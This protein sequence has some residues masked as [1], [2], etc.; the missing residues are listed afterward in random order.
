LFSSLADTILTVYR[1]FGRGRGSA[2][3][4]GE[5]ESPRASSGGAAA[6]GGESLE[7]RS[8]DD[9]EEPGVSR[10]RG[11]LFRVARLHTV[12]HG[13]RSANEAGAV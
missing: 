12:L 5:G 7:R 11:P 8:K 2:R 10:C 13:Q 9:E 4:A 6:T 1:C 3:P